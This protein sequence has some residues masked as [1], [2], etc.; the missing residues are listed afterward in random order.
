MYSLFSNKY[1]FISIIS[2]IILFIQTNLPSIILY[3]NNNINLDLVLI[4][5]TVLVFLKNSYKVIILA[6]IYG[7]VQDMVMSVDQLGVFSFIK[8]TTAFLL[9]YVRKYDTIWDKKMKFLYVFLIY[10][11]HFLVYYSIIYN[12]FYFIIFSISFFQS[13]STFILFILANRFFI[14]IK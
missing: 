12:D 9:L 1:Y 11:L 4:F 7:L 13:V 14:K 5:L 8:S 10:F 2:L 6:F 3:G